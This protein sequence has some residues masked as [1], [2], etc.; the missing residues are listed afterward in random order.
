[1]RSLSRKADKDKM[2]EL[3]EEVRQIRQFQE[4]EDV[5]AQLEASSQIWDAPGPATQIFF[6]PWSYI[7]TP[8]LWWPWECSL[9]SKTFTS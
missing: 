3:E 8:R 1:M 4:D 2:S 6:E 5:E 9:K 7:G